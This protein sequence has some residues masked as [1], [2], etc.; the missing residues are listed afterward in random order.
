MPDK[1]VDAKMLRAYL[2]FKTVQQ[3]DRWCEKW[4][5]APAS[6]EGKR[7]RLYLTTDYLAAYARCS[8]SETRGPAI[9][10]T[11]PM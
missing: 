3:F 6:P 10:R 5:L 4:G 8:R 7:P 9:E 1:Y 11:T 2:G